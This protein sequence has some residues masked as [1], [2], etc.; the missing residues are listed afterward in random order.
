MNR[1]VTPPRSS[2]VGAAGEDDRPFNEVFQLAYI[3][4]PRPAHQGPHRIGRNLVDLFVHFQ[5]VLLGEVPGEYGYVLGMIAQRRRRDR[6]H[7]Q[8]VVEI[9]P[10]ELVP[11][12][13]REVP[14]RGRHQPDVDG[15][16]LGAAQ[17]LERLL[18]QCAQQLR[19]EIQGNIAY[20]VQ[21]Q[22]PSMSHLKPPDLLR[23]GAREGAPLIANSSLSSSPVG[24]AAQFKVIKGRSRRGL[25][26]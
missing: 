1:T 15:D 5:G 18:L 25:M 23:Q 24:M 22:R 20:F 17:S 16:R 8:A 21:K 3:A 14:V 11:H 4:R 13:L 26:R 10:E 6:E 9:T 7:F 2:E 12:H 19:L